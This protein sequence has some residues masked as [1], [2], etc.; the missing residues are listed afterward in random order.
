MKTSQL[1]S[2]GEQQTLLSVD[3]ALQVVETLLHNSEPLSARAIAV[4][5][6]INRTTAHRVLN[7]L[8]H[9][10]WIEKPAGSA[11]YRLSVRFWALVR[12]SPHSRSFL[13]EIR[14]ALEHLSQLSR[15]TVHLGVLDGFE[16]L[17]VDKIDSLEHYGISS[18]IGSRDAAHVTGLGK[19]LLAASPDAFVERYLS[20]ATAPGS[21]QPIANPAAFRAEIR[22]T[23]QRGYAIDNEE[24]SLGVR[25][26]GVAVVGAGNI[27]LFALSLTGPSP[28][29][30]ASRVEELAP[31]AMAMTQ[32]L[33]RRF[34][35]EQGFDSP[36]PAGSND[37]A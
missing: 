5:V 4:H 29:F 11:A 10:G 31:V 33:S 16:I 6:G 1:A 18:Q 36:E 19:A 26:L 17:H 30:T 24:A 25:C 2:L 7:A 12:V 22:R 32:E 14:P 9:R 37:D 3:K 21:R 20:H 35:W 27:P 15:E 23:R 13:Q 28:R 8:M 34:G